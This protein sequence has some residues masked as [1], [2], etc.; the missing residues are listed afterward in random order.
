[1]RRLFSL[2]FIVGG[3]FFGA[4][5][6]MIFW[7][8]LAEDFGLP[9]IS[10]AQAMVLTGGLWLVILPLAS[11]ARVRLRYLDPVGGFFFASWLL[12]IFWGIFAEDLALPTVSYVKAMGLTIGLWL[13]AA[14]LVVAARR[15]VPGDSSGPWRDW[16]SSWRQDADST[17]ESPSDDRGNEAASLKIRVYR[18]GNATPEKTITIPRK[19]V[20][21]GSKFVKL[22]P[23]KAVEALS[24]KGIDIDELVALADDP[25]THGTI[26][27][28]EDH[29]EGKRIVISF[30]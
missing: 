19:L 29:D 21:V 22:L 28:V 14:P 12:M 24:S 16:A 25:D 6:A 4:W 2:P 5:V 7:G 3:F 10:Y 30:E 11:G 23:K 17:G 1:M 15:E 20:K 26:L 9:T 18:R 8:M 13:A 27:E